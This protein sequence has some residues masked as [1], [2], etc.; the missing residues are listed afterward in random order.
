[1]YADGTICDSSGERRN[2]PLDSSS[3]NL[4]EQLYR[5][6]SLD[7][8][9]NLSKTNINQ[10]GN[11]ARIGTAVVDAPVVDLSFNYFLADAYN[12][13][14]L[15]FAIDGEHQALYQM[16]GET[17][18]DRTTE[19]KNYHI[20]VG[21]PNDDVNDTNLTT[22]ESEQAVIS[23]GQGYITQYTVT[24]AVGEIPSAQI[25]IQG[26]NMKSDT[27]FQNILHPGPSDCGYTRNCEYCFSLP[28]PVTNILYSTLVSGES[29]CCEQITTGVNALL[30][31]DICIN[32]R[33][34]SLLSQQINRTGSGVCSLTANCEE[35]PGSA[36]IQGFQI[37]A[38]LTR[39]SLDKL[40]RHT[41]YYQSVNVPASV[42][43]SVDALVSDLKV[44]NLQSYLCSS[45]L[46]D[47]EI[48]LYPPCGGSND[49]S[50]TAIEPNMIYK[51]KC[52]K[53][54]S[55]GFQSAIG[56]NKTVRLTFSAPIGG[57]TDTECGFFMSGRAAGLASYIKR[58][59][60]TGYCIDYITR[61]IPLATGSC[62]FIKTEKQRG[63]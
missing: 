32:L 16:L 45:G 56:N 10:F 46:K 25:S 28:D 8:G 49:C 4:V 24:A 22:K 60:Q 35:D 34:S 41:A 61:S 33:N 62:S 7:Y 40:G 59:R 50:V 23:I 9:F 29:G 36:H 39:S 13:L 20:L 26:S 1:M 17:V 14:L 48:V 47:I 42:E 27:G 44:G 43:L 57:R 21:P 6:Q 15:D 11:A 19:A 53:L 30:P 5:I 54:E 12:E 3:G 55:E 51:L 38:D 58:E 52:A 31:G 2:I 18:S 37:S 63:T